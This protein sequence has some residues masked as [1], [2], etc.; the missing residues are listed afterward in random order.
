M[1]T[2]IN[3]LPFDK[4]RTLTQT[5]MGKQIIKVIKSLLENYVEVH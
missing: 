5:D 2:K 1:Q 4:M 3:F